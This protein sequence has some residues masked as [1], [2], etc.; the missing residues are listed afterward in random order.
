MLPFSWQFFLTEPIILFEDAYWF[1]VHKPAGMPCQGEKSVTEWAV[2]FCLDLK[3]LGLD[4]EYGLVHRLDNPTSGVLLFA[5]KKEE[6]LRLRSLW[7]QIAVKKEY[8][9]L[10]L[11]PEKQIKTPYQL[12]LWIGHDKKAKHKM[13]ADENPDRLKMKIRSHARQG[14]TQILSQE[15]LTLKSPQTDLEASFVQWHVQIKTGL[16][17]QIR[18]SFAWLK[19]PLIGDVRYKGVSASRL[20]LHA[21]RMTLLHPEGKTRTLLAPLLNKRLE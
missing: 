4:Y 15:K 14:I 19:C 6:Y 5:K 2:C 13:R 11:L 17:H 10:T 7:S 18:L 21:W 3:N 1:A 16:R 8:L 20:C 12:S 9:C